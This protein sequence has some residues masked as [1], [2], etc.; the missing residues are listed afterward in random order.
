MKIYFAASIRGGRDDQK[1]YIDIIKMLKKYGEVLTEHIGSKDLLEQ[2]EIEMS[3]NAIFARDCALLDQCDIIVAEV[4]NPSLGV[5]YEIGR[6]ENKKPV[7]CLYRQ[8]DGK[9]L[10]AMLAG[11]DNLLVAN[12]KNLKDIEMVLENF[13]RKI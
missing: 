7:L 13:F 12:Y 2:G 1:L 3:D 8:Q 4:T 6:M 11:N 9:R 10:S 5:G